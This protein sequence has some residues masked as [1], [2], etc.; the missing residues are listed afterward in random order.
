MDTQRGQKSAGLRLMRSIKSWF[1]FLRR[2]AKKQAEG[3]G[4]VEYG[5]ILLLIAL[6]VIVALV[7]LGPQIG[8]LFSAVT[9]GFS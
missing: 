8:S 9:K 3:Q 4:L 7:A 5:L 1:D 6:V 2:D